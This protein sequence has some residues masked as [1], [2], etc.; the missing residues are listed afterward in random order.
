MRSYLD[1][2]I[3]NTAD[4]NIELLAWLID[5]ESR[6]Y[7]R[8]MGYLTSLAEQNSQENSESNHRV[9]QVS[10]KD[11]TQNKAGNGGSGSQYFVSERM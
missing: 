4:K 7:D 1:K 11:Q 9:G 2:K 8:F 3:V 10:L 6:P 5:F